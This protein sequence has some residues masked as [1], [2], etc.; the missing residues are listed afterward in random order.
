MWLL[1]QEAGITAIVYRLGRWRSKR[2]RLSVITLVPVPSLS[3]QGFD[4]K[5]SLVGCY[6]TLW[7]S[8]RPEGMGPA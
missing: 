8:G 4:A 6:F 1:S 5:H 7:Y 2:R 3:G